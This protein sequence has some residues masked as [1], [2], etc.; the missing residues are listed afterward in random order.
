MHYLSWC[1]ALTS[2]CT[3]CAISSRSWSPVRAHCAVTCQ[4]FSFYVNEENSAAVCWTYASYSEGSNYGLTRDQLPCFVSYSG[5]RGFELRTAQT[6]DVCL[7]FWRS[8]PRIT[9]GPEISCLAFL[10][11]GGGGGLDSSDPYRVN[12]VIPSYEVTKHYL[13]SSH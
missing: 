5:D 10:F 9:Y 12:R 4:V 1:S 7:L 2:R 6:L 11:L 3:V 8:W 13:L